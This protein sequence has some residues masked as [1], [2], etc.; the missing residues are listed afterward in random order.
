MFFGF[1]R[2]LGNNITQ[3]FAALR[4][5]RTKEAETFGFALTSKIQN[6]L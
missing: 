1:L 4:L 2:P 5:L 3:R 6:K